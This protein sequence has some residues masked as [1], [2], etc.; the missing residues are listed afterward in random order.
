MIILPRISVQLTQRPIESYVPRRRPLRARIVSLH[1]G[2]VKSACRPLFNSL[3]DGLVRPELHLCRRSVSSFRVYGLGGSIVA[4]CLALSLIWQTG[5]SYTVFT[6]IVI[7]A[8]MAFL[9]VAMV[10]K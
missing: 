3:V 1:A 7:A 6:G 10:T 2:I 9:V 4:C 8:V 5:L